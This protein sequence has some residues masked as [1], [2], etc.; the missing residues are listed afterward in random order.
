MAYEEIY[1]VEEP[2]VVIPAHVQKARYRRT[3]DYNF[4]AGDNIKIGGA[5]NG[6]I[7]QFCEYVVP[8]PPAPPGYKMKLLLDVRIVEVLDTA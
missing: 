5:L 7:K 8:N 6:D 4:Q 3:F 2:Q 1:D